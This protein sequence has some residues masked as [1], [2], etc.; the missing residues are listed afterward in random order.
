[1]KVPR[2]GGIVVVYMPDLSTV[3]R[4]KAVTPLRG[5]GAE[6]ETTPAKLADGFT[7]YHVAYSK[8]LG[9]AHAMLMTRYGLRKLDVAAV[10]FNCSNGVSFTPV[11]IDLTKTRISLSLY[12]HPAA[13][14][15][16][17]VSYP[18]ISV[19]VDLTAASC[20]LQGESIT[21][22]VAT[23]LVVKLD[24][25]VTLSASGKVS[26]S[27]PWYPRFTVGFDH[28]PDANSNYH[29]FGQSSNVSVKVAAS[30]TMFVGFNAAIMLGGVVGVGGTLGGEL[31]ASLEAGK[32][33]L[34]IDGALNVGLTANVS[35]WVT[36]WTF[37]IARGHLA[38]YIWASSA[39]RQAEV[40]PA[41]AELGRRCRPAASERWCRRGLV[42]HSGSWR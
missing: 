1:M 35:V 34:N 3:G 2:V 22:P 26:A 8:D 28:G 18:T 21:I 19:G 25:I 38:L 11:T 5:G 32:P 4:V 40:E 10:G 16:L 36:N 14:D 37:T 30:A 39:A 15:F 42:G 24:P 6:I 27:F 29:D 13:I 31:T 9:N 17:F 33:C 20:S 41:V 12:L 23:G 7:R